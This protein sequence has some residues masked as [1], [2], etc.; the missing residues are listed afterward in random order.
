[1]KLVLMDWEKELE[2]RESRMCSGWFSK[3]K[4]KGGLECRGRVSRAGW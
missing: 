1:M 2:S 4:G 3:S